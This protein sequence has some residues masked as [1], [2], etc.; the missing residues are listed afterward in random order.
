MST[1]P[2]T[3]ANFD[4]YQ[5]AGH[6]AIVTGGTRGIGRATAKQ[7]AA[8]GAN[9]F[10]TSRK[11][12]AADTAATELNAELADWAKAA[13]AAGTA[14]AGSL[15]RII[16]VAGHAGDADAATAVCDRAA[17]EFG[18]LDILVNN[19]GTNPAFGPVHQ[20]SPE[21][22]QKV[23]A[24]NATAP[25]IWAGAAVSAG[26]GKLRQGTIV[27]VSSIGALTMED[28]IGIYNASK[29]A[30]V[31]LTKQMARELAPNI[32]VNAI[33][34]GVVRTK[35]SEA[36]WK[37]NEAAVNAI[38]PLARIGEPEDIAEAITFLA[39]PNSSWI[40]GANL[41]IDGGQLVGGN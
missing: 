15:G 35:L 30:L 9:V 5:L 23:F 29:A 12:D 32:R 10:I 13:G 31:H 16:G 22:I 41:V 6:T 8:C 38:T 24:I 39:A 27:N 7:L 34:P 3:T 19:A 20:Q 28:H 14:G 25:A 33:S 36:L 2:N 4:R 21:V 26:L 37:E 18:S 40:T 1:S 11:Q 17:E